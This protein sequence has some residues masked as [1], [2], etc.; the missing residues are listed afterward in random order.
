M[1]EQTDHPSTTTP[2]FPSAPEIL[3]R[4]RVPFPDALKEQKQGKDYVPGWAYWARMIDD[5]GAYDF[6]ILSSELTT[7]KLLRKIDGSTQRELV[8]IPAYVVTAEL[9]I[10]G[11]GTRAGRGVQLLEDNAGED[12]SKGA[13]TD[14]FKRCC[15]L[16]GLGL[17]LYTKGKATRR[18]PHPGDTPRARKV[19]DAVVDAVVAA[20]SENPE[21]AAQR[22]PSRDETRRQGSILP[23]QERTIR[24]LWQKRYPGGEEHVDDA[25]NDWLADNDLPPLD[26]LEQDQAGEL[27]TVLQKKD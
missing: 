7:F 6:R 9:T 17:D 24:R 14:A 27:I 26:Q 25:I 3:E 13:E 12:V 20:V 21:P 10:P 1:T 18:A 4:L 19:A 5:V 15:V 8:D 11:L 16:F 2:S 23:Q 22:P